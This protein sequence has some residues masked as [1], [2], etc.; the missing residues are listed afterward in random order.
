MSAEPSGLERVFFPV[1]T[2]AEIDGWVLRVVDR[3]LGWRTSGLAF[4]SGRI[5]SVYGVHV[6]NGESV[7]SGCTDHLWTSAPWRLV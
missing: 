7:C 2:R 4:R 5:D 6:V 3:Q 1:H